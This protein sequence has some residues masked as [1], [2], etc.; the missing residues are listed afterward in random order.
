MGFLNNMIFRIFKFWFSEYEP[1]DRT[2]DD[3]FSIVLLKFDEQ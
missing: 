1:S 3:P 2:L